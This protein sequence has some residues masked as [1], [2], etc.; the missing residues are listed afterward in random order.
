[1]RHKLLPGKL[2]FV[3]DERTQELHF[4]AQ[5]TDHFAVVGAIAAGLCLAAVLF[6]LRH[7]AQVTGHLVF[8]HV[9]EAVHIRVKDAGQFVQTF[10]GYFGLSAFNI[11]VCGRGKAKLTGHSPLGQVTQFA[12]PADITAYG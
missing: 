5:V 1:M 3:A 9:N 6:R 12:H 10:Q 2:A 4:F 11:T 7:T 8:R